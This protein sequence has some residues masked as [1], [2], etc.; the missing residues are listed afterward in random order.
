MDVSF[1]GLENY[2]DPLIL[3]LSFLFGYSVLYFLYFR[4]LDKRKKEELWIK[5]WDSSDRVIL[6]LLIGLMFYFIIA[7]PLSNIITFLNYFNIKIEFL[8]CCYI[9]LLSGIATMWLWRIGNVSKEDIQ[10]YRYSL[11]IS[12]ILFLSGILLISLSIL[13]TL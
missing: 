8:F 1:F 2:I 9:I 3:I 7:F 5:K 10:L 11:T 6:S 13:K 12:Y 4:K